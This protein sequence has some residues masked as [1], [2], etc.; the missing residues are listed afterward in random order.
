MF[1]RSSFVVLGR[2]PDRAVSSPSIW[3]TAVRIPLGSI[4]GRNHDASRFQF[5]A[6]SVKVVVA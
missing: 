6:V 4:S 5:T 1:Q 2:G 3:Q